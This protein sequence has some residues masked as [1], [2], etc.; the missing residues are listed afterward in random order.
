MTGNNIKL[1]FS[2][3]SGNYEI[4]HNGFSW[5]SDGRKPYITVRRK[6][7]NKYIAISRS[8]RSASKKNTSFSDRKIV[9]R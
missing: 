8:L 9:T 2:E 6:V 3:F 1:K 4:T 7:G 5:I